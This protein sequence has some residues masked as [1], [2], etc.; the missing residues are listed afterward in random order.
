MYFVFDFMFMF[1][2]SYYRILSRVPCAIYYRSCVIFL[3]NTFLKLRNKR[4]EEEQAKETKKEVP[5]R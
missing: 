1:H 4:E 2:M 3:K 5:T